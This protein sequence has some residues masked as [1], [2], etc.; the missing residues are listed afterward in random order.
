MT[1]FS[2]A[3]VSLLRHT[4]MSSYLAKRRNKW[5]CALKTAL[6]ELKVYGPKGN[7]DT[8]PSTT[9]YTRVPWELVQ[10]QDREEAGKDTSSEVHVP[11]GGWHLRGNSDMIG[12]HRTTAPY[13]YENSVKLTGKLQLIPSTPFSG[14]PVRWALC[15][16]N[17]CKKFRMLTDVGDI[18]TND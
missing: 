5:I 18:G 1:L 15:A 7:P 14:K 16:V 13:I 11:R 9:R 8:G 17:F 10:A 4:H 6:G 2:N 12:K 3:H